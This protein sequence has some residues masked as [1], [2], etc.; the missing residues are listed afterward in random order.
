MKDGASPQ[1]KYQ[2]TMITTVS[3]TNNSED[4]EHI[5]TPFIEGNPAYIKMEASFTKNLGDFNFSKV[6]VSLNYPCNPNS[7]DADFEKIKSWVDA[8]MT[9]TLEK[10]ENQI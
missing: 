3:A 4:H 1:T 10:M 8:K 6:G 9:S 7:I 5:L 2:A